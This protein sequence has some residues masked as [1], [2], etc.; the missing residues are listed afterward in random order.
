MYEIDKLDV[1]IVNLLL[2]DGPA[3][4]RTSRSEQFGIGSTGW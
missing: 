4:L 2:D 1:K 3:V